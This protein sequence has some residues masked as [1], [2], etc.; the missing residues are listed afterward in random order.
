[1]KRAQICSSIVAILVA[2]SGLAAA[3]PPPTTAPVEHHSAFGAPRT[4]T[5]AN[6]TVVVS[7]EAAGDLRGLV[8][9]TLR[10]ADGGGYAGEWAF[11]VAHA[12]H[13]DPA[14]GEDPELEHAFGGSEGTDDTG[15]EPAHKAF[16]TLVHQGS[17]A[18]AVSHADLT[19]G[20]DGGLTRLQATLTV[21]QGA[22][23]FS[24]ATGSGQ[25]TLDGLHLLF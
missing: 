4:S 21:D 11:T 15:Q 19:Q 5:L 24:G 16:V 13:T 12:D 8:T 14:T 9:L 1:M 20:A 10:S 18:G 23:E 3:A 25:A 7:F 17:L 22:S 2:V 6:G